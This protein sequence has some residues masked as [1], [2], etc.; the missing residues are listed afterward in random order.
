MANKPSRIIQCDKQGNDL[1]EFSSAKEAQ[2]FFGSKTGNSISKAIKH[3]NCAFGFRW[4]YVG[5]P[6]FIK[7]EGTPGKR[8]AIIAD[9][10]KGAET[11]YPSISEASR[12]T[13][14]GI[15]SIESSLLMGC[16]VKGYRFRYEG[17]KFSESF[18]HKRNRR[19]VL[20]LDDDGNVIKEY[21]SAYD[22]AKNLGVIP[23]AVYRCL[24]GDNPNARCKGHRLRFK[25]EE[26]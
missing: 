10:L 1:R 24:R 11:S 3:G 14:I 16:T 7:P 20:V 18:K 6:L 2:L 17:E 12:K 9:D 13:D 21:E 23:G 26:E 8:R 4:R 25:P 19:K 15:T 5:Q 22:C